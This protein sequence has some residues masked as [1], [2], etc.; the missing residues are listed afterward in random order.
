[1]ENN[2]KKNIFFLYYQHNLASAIVSKSHEI[3][4][5]HFA[6]I[7]PPL[8]AVTLLERY[9]SYFHRIINIFF[10]FVFEIYKLT[11]AAMLIDVGKCSF[12]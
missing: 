7:L 11:A 2:C 5:V 12:V 6:L 3:R 4:F 9:D 10:V 1:M 8:I